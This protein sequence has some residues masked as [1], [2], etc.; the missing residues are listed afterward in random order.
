[1][2]VNNGIAPPLTKLLSEGEVLLL[3]DP[4]QVW[5][6]QSGSMAIFASHVQNGS[7][8]GSRQYLFT[9]EMGE[10]LF[11]FLTAVSSSGH[12]E[13]NPFYILAVP[14]TDTTLLRFQR[15]QVDGDISPGTNFG[16]THSLL[17]TWFERL[18]SALNSTG[19]PLPVPEISE[20]TPSL[21]QLTI[22]DNFHEQFLGSLQELEQQAQLEMLA[23]FQARESLNREA[24]AGAIAS[25]ISLV[26]PKE[27]SA[28][29]VGNP[30][31]AA[32]GAVGHAMGIQIQPPAQSENIKR[33]KEPLEAIARAS[34]M[35]I[36]RVVLTE[37][38]WRDDCGPLV[39]YLQADNTPVALL[40]NAKNH[41][42]IYHPIAQ[43]RIRL[44]EKT[45]KL[46]SPTA[47]MF[48][49]PFPEKK[50]DLLTLFQYS[51][52]GRGQE[53]RNIIFTGI[54]GTIAGMV[55]PQATGILIDTA[56]P[57]ADRGLLL[58]LTL[59][60]FAAS[61]G[62]ALFRLTQGINLGRFEVY[63]LLNLQ[64]AMWDRVLK[65]RLAFFR[66]YSS[67]EML[68]RVNSITQIRDKLGADKLD[69][70]SKSFFLY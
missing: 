53:L 47:Y 3:D 29:F 67:G 17:S 14:T 52:R 30:L 61:F 26:K 46:L 57:D 12:E 19:I 43:K 32:A 4:Q 28:T 21:T 35:R 65:L 15:S 39:G 24:T 31:L 38:W 44:G 33:V 13:P 25:F 62:S 40:L 7:L 55:V 41:Y 22:L 23:Q 9:A 70:I 6:I 10:V 66:N 36:R 34:R 63:S 37:R 42:E 18:S 1:M 45:A 49:P 11:G 56:V 69:V 58:Q 2:I 48:Y 16:S 60:L 59:A 51:L 5:A 54:A 20:Q 8:Q 64:S 27:V 50:L 68:S